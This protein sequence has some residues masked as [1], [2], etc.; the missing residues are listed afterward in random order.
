MGILSNTLANTNPA[1]DT[2]NLLV[3]EL[4]DYNVL[5][6]SP[7]VT[8]DFIK[9]ESNDLGNSKLPNMTTDGEKAKKKSRKR[10][11]TTI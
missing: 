1:E 6:S 7:T 9:K 11:R 5:T 10:V 2:Y 4:L 3:D 8:T